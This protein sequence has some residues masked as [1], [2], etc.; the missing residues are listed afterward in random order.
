VTAEYP[1]P[2]PSAKSRERL[3]HNAGERET[4]T[5]CRGERERREEDEREREKGWMD[6]ES[7]FAFQ[8]YANEHHGKIGHI[9]W[10]QEPLPKCGDPLFYPHDSFLSFY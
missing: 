8:R 5:Q 6:G 3:S 4:L 7:Y 9:L 10:I 2:I 1:I